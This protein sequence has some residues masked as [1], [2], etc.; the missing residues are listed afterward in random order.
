M[1]STNTHLQDSRRHFTGHGLEAG[2]KERGNALAQAAQEIGGVTIS[3]GAPEPW[4]CSTKGHGQW[5]WWGE[6]VG[7]G[8]DLKGLSQ[9]S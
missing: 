7:I 3:R 6:M 5:G 8:L 1:S 2:Q 4:G 9:P